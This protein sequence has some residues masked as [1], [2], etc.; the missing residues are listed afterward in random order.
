MA[1]VEEVPREEEV[2]KNEEEVLKK[3]EEVFKIKEEV[4]A[5]EDYPMDSIDDGKADIDCAKEE[6]EEM[7][8]GSI[9]AKDEMADDSSESAKSDKCTDSPPKKPTE[10]RISPEKSA[11]QSPEKIEQNESEAREDKGDE[12]E[13]E[14]GDTKEEEEKK[15][16]EEEKEEKEEE[17]EEKEENGDKKEEEEEKENI[18]EKENKKEDEE[19]NG[20]KDD[21]EEEEEEEEG[22]KKKGLFELPLVI[23]GTR[24]RKSTSFLKVEEIHHTKHK[25]PAVAGSGTAL[26]DIPFVAHQIE[27]EKKVIDLRPLYRI[28]Y[29]AQG[30]TTTLRR[31]LKKFNGFSFA[32]N[33]EEYKR[34]HLVTN[35]FTRAD[36]AHVRRILGIASG[37]TKE[38]E[39]HNIIDFLLLPHD[40]GK[41]VPKKRKSG[42]KTPKK[43]PKKRA[44]DDQ[45]TTTPSKKVKK[46]DS[47]G[48]GGEEND[49]DLS[50][51]SDEEKNKLTP[52]DNEIKAK[53]DE[54]VKTFDLSTVNMKQ[55][56]AAVVDSFPSH[57]LLV[58]RAPTIKVFIK[59][60]IKDDE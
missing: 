19:E 49:D 14:S 5:N 57:P 17:E 11:E 1:E 4:T 58:E 56:V 22:E 3:E 10:D 2:S 35:K 43:T 28:C 37:K 48:E 29:G 32:K 8:I 41:S 45:S 53:I 33:S 46:A 12:V 34:K 44:A 23:E 24:N 16:M 52:S 20:E 60:A 30:K 18:E 36:L 55:M 39:V 15:E 40:E 50:S 31:E 27:S 25:A 51:D 6:V 13:E 42:G 38:D 26:E 54:L 59:E 21:D 47:E 7:A 9:E